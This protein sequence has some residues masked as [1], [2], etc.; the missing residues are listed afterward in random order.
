MLP[1][2]KQTV[3]IKIINVSN[4]VRL[5]LYIEHNAKSSIYK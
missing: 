5:I 3:N 2:Y 4:C 1:F